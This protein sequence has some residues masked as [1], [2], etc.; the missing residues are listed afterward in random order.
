[1]VL[2]LQFNRLRSSLSTLVTSRYS[3]F[4]LLSVSYCACLLN[5]NSLPLPI[6]D[7]LC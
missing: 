2:S 4:I 1:M 6:I 7:I 5:Y 3:F